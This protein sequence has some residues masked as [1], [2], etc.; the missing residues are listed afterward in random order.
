MLSLDQPQ[1]R[2]LLQYCS[3]SHI[4][5]P[6]RNEL[7]PIPVSLPTIEA[8]DWLNEPGSLDKPALVRQVAG[9]ANQYMKWGSTVTCS[10]S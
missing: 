9:N 8:D 2:S 3:P 5:P 7:S 1:T 6:R 10:S 4:A